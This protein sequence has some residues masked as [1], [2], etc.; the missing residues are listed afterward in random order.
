L[1]VEGDVALDGP[2]EVV[3]LRPE[4]NVAAGRAQHSLADALPS[5]EGGRLVLVVRDAHRH[6]WMR[7]RVEAHPEAIVVEVGLPHWRPPAA[8]GYV[9]SYG[10][11]HASFEAIAELLG[12]EVPV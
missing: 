3:E 8:R 5:T 11:S 1:R 2:A 4:A 7:E 12:A 9:A 10:G 6:P